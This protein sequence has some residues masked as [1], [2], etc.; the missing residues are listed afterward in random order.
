LAATR[1]F[2]TPAIAHYGDGAMIRF[3]EPRLVAPHAVS[4][5]LSCGRSA[6]LGHPVCRPVAGPA[7]T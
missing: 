7:G 4:R 1:E 2:V 5:F 6:I 3:S